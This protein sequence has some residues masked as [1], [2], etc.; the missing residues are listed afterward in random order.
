MTT[1]KFKSPASNY[2][3]E[4]YAK[5]KKYQKKYGFEIGKGNLDTWNNE[6]DAFKHTFAA[7]DIALRYNKNISEVM[8]NIHEL[9][10]RITMGQSSGE[11]NMDKWNNEI[12]RRIAK[13]IKEENR[14]KLIKRS[15]LDD[16]IAE[17]VMEKMRN[18]ELITNPNDTRKYRSPGE[19]FTDEIKE[20]WRNMQQSRNP[21]LQNRS[22]KGKK[23]SASG[24][25]NG[26]W[27]TINGNH[28][29]IEK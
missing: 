2:S 27:I 9:Q 5:T 10:G 17:K 8:G 11:E 1:N 15:E 25:T 19:K 6:A 20:K 13:E 23:S 24:T 22:S 14:N 26:K 18:G 21:R 7:A 12:G 16:K 3:S 28:V 4:V 29:F